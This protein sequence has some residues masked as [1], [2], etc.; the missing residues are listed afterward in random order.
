MSLCQQTEAA[1]HLSESGLAR[2]PDNRSERMC[3]IKPCS[4]RASPTQPAIC[5]TENSGKS[6][7]TLAAFTI[8]LD[9]RH[10]NVSLYANSR[11][12]NKAAYSRAVI[13]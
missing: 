2:V 1:W 5:L 8:G 12:E 3:E 11:G 4:H 9:E 7:V 6:V 13:I 10:R